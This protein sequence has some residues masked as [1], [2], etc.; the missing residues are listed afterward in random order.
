[1]V[2]GLSLI[3]GRKRTWLGRKPLTKGGSI[4]FSYR[5]QLLVKLMIPRTIMLKFRWNLA[6]MFLSN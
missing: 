3:N 5:E 4:R 2:S 6:F 1:M